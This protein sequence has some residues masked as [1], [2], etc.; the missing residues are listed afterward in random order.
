MLKLWSVLTAA[1]LANLA[2]AGPAASG[3][4]TAMAPLDQY[5]ASDEA[6]LARSAAPPSISDDAEILVLGAHGYETAAKG[7]NGFAC[8]VERG[9]ANEFASPD[10]W[11][12]KIRGPICFNPASARSV[13]PTY[14]MRTEWVLAGLDKAQILDR[15]KAAIAAGKVVAPTPGAMCYMMSK[16]GFLDDTAG[17]WRPHLMFFTPRTPAAAWGANLKGSPVGGGDNGDVDPAT[18][19]LVPVGAWSDGTPAPPMHM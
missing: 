18:V 1:G 17:H 7:K 9:W 6:A 19:F 8:I 5:K 15:T 4:Y 13:L 10:F 3:A 11:N 2:L 16:D 12:P 14:L